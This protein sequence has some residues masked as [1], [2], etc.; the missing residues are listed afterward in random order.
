MKRARGFSLVEVLVAF[1]LLASAMGIL[2]AIL[3]GGL[4]QVHTSSEATRATLL[5]ESVLAEQGVLGPIE[6]GEQ[7]G[8]SED[9][10]FRWTLRVQEIPDPAPVAAAV[11]GLEPVET[12]GRVQPNAPVLYE[13]QLEVAWGRDEY[14]RQLA[15]S[16]VRARYPQ[17]V[18][19]EI[20]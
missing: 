18:P 7:R 2:V 12:A 10:R 6:P 19:G 4:A 20:Q 9:G 8:E 17:S 3:G 16:T 1:V 5:A 13:L 14:A 15:F 11:P